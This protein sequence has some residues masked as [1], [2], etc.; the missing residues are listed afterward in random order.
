MAALLAAFTYVLISGNNRAMIVLLPL[1]QPYRCVGKD[2]PFQSSSLCHT[3]EHIY[4][5]DFV[6]AWLIIVRTL[7]HP[8]PK[9]SR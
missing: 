4:G 2:G 1:A 9:V 8:L 6:Y 7:S 3:I 5:C